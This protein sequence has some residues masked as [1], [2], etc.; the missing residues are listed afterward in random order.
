MEIILLDE[1]LLFPDPRLA[2]KDAPLAFGGDLS[3]Q[4][5][6]LAYSLGIFPWFNA[7]DPIMWF[8]P[9]PRFVLRPKELVINRS[10]R[11]AMKKA[12]YQL[13]MDTAFAD[14]IQACSSTP[15]PKQ[16]GTW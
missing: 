16:S 7:E 9:D 13:T 1:R 12:P 5:L 8:S 14:V 11:K 10:L 4:R 2:P 6:L 3:P 15:R